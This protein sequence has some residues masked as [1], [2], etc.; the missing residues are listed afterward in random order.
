MK[1][2]IELSNILDFGRKKENHVFENYDEQYFP[3][4]PTGELSSSQM[5]EYWSEL[6]KKRGIDYPP[7]YF[8]MSKNFGIVFN[9]TKV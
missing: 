2:N 3:P 4:R 7:E 8:D 9:I 5:F 1:V 6:F